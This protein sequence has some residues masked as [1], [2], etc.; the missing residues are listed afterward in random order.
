MAP[1]TSNANSYSDGPHAC[2]PYAERRVLAF[3]HDGSNGRSAA[4]VLSNWSVVSTTAGTSGATGVLDL[5][6]GTQVTIVIS[7]GT[8]SYECVFTMTTTTVTVTSF[9]KI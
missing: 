5:P 9:Q 6:T 2:E 3:S 7:D 1:G 8:D 4:F